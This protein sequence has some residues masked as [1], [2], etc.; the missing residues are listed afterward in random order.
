[1]NEEDMPGK[2]ALRRIAA[3]CRENGVEPVFMAIPAPVNAQEQMN[4]NSVQLIADELGVPFLNLFEEEGLLD[5]ESDCYDYLGHLN[6]DGA[7]KLTAYLGKWLTENYD[8]ADRRGDVALGHWD[9][10]LALFEQHREAVWGE[11]TRLD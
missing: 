6:P 3:L 1:M 4:M 10:N 2:D 7:S 8:L 11:M 9:E 5:F